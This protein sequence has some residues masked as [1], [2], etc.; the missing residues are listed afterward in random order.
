[1]KFNRAHSWII[2]LELLVLLLAFAVRLAY[3]NELRQLY[4][5]FLVNQP[6]CGLDANSYH[7]IYA[8][9]LLNGTWPGNEPY[10]HMILYPYYLAGIYALVGI[11][12]RVVVV[13]HILLEVVTCAS[14]YRIGRLAFNRP[15][16]LLASF[17]FAIYAPTIF[18]NPCY[19]QVALSVPLFVVTLFLLL[20]MHKTNRLGY[21]IGAG[22]TTGLAVLSRPTFFQLVP[23]IGI[24]WLVN[25][26]PWRRI[27]LQAITY[28]A[29]IFLVTLPATLHNYRTAG[30]FSPMPVSGWEIFFLGNNPYAEGMGWVDYVLYNHFDVEGE[31]YAIDVRARANQSSS[32]VYREEAFRYIVTN[33][34]DWLN[35]LWRKTYLLVG[36]SDDQ[37]ISPYFVHNLQAVAFMHY[38]PLGW[39]VGFIAA[40]LGMLLV[41]HKH[42]FLLVLLLVAL[43][44]FTIMFHIQYRFRL[45]LVPLVM[46]YAAALIVEAP[47]LSRWRFMAALAVL[48]GLT[49]WLPSLGWMLGLF[50]LFTVYPLLQNKQWRQFG[51]AAIVIWGYAVVALLMGQIFYF[52]H[53]SRQTQALF[54]GPSISGPLA[55]GQSFVVHCNG[56][57]RVSLN[58]GLPG[59]VQREPATFHLRAAA[60]SPDDIYSTPIDT[61]G[62][63]DRVWY[64]ITFPAQ[65]NSARQ[66]Y[67]L[68]IDAPQVTSNRAMT[69][70]GTYDQ[71]FDRYREGTAYVGRPGAWQEIPGD[72]AF[73]AFCDDNPLAIANQALAQWLGRAWMLGWML[74]VIHLGLL[75]WAALKLWKLTN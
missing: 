13:I 18:F 27:V 5:E 75:I 35:L 36:E 43:I 64:N 14:L 59:E 22:L 6:F 23:I 19:A 58:L 55:L 3:F 45:L 42:K 41:K 8:K 10:F 20:K 49:P 54:L 28:G 15:A 66:S 69:L 71:P 31:Q 47:K 67:F 50:L 38:L 73:S 25:R 53:Q 21:L 16:G 2:V 24:W 68:F 33:P 11:S 65:A 61:S 26:L 72:L 9:G 74:L 63:Q 32:D 7:Q 60:D 37:L 46:L 30:F 17:F 29:I 44:G 51:W 39:R 48:A 56:F 62:V 1:M 52:T 12:L 34:V 4:P 40:L 70:R 57:N